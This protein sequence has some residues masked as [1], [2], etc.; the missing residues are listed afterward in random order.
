MMGEALTLTVGPARDGRKLAIITT[1][2]HPQLPGSG[3]TVVL[4][5]E[6]I[7]GWG[8]KKLEDWFNRMGE[9]RPWEARQ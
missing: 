2:G 7:D 9:E 5:V 8:R 6:V 4:H 1:G 3:P